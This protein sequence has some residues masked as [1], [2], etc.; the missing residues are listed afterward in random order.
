[1][2][3]LGGAYFSLV[4][5]PMWAERLTAGPRLDRAGAGGLR[6]VAA[7]AAAARRLS[8]RRG[9]DL[10]APGQGRRASASCAP[11]FLAALPYLATILVL[12]LISIA[13][14]RSAPRRRPAS[15][16]RSSP[17]SLRPTGRRTRMTLITRRTL[18]KAGGRG[19]GPAAARRPRL[20]AGAAQG[21]LHLR[22]P[23]R[24]LRLD[25]RPRPGPPGRRGRTSA[26]RSRRPIV[27]NVAEGPDGERVIRNLAQD[28]N[29]LIF[30]TLVRLHEPDDQGGQ[31]LP[32]REVRA[33]LRL[34]ARRQRRDLQRP[35][36]RGPR[37]LRHA[38]PGT[39]RRPG[40]AG[41]IASFP[42]PEV[43]MGI[44]ALHARGAQGEPGLQDQGGLGLDAGT[45]RPRRPTRPRR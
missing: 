24:R 3:G 27:E 4:Q 41:Y 1:M 33:L 11:E 31:A 30:T 40:I 25:L 45:T 35:L 5:T 14:G 42:I 37:G 23:G 18:L 28:G 26:T 32:G 6:G 44:N 17:T 36:L 34:P 8:L 13:R 43:V 19:R 2:A 21:R 29:Q 15:A 22:R 10:R 20:R 7:V 38:S 12:A 9:D 16:S 39:C